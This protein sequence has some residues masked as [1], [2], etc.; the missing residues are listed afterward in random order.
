MLDDLLTIR[1]ASERYKL[2]GSYLRRLIKDKRIRGRKLGTTWALDP[3]S[4]EEFLKY[5]RP[6]T[7]RPIDK[8]IK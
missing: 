7:G 3:A 6:K 4:I 2:S 1:E 8:T 5:P